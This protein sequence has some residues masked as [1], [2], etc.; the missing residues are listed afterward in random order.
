MQQKGFVQI[1]EK[2]GEMQEQELS[3]EDLDPQQKAYRWQEK[4]LIQ[5]KSNQS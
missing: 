3:E 1:V 5:K 4:T 2:D